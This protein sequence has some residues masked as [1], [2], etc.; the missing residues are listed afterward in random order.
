MGEGSHI[1]SF[2]QGPVSQWSARLYHSK[3]VS[4]GFNKGE[5]RLSLRI[6]KQL[7]QIA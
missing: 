7:Q 1:M 2:G 3:A 6:Q 4:Q 5:P